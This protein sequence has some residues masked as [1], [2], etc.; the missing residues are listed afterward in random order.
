MDRDSRRVAV[1]SGV[2]LGDAFLVCHQSTQ[3]TEAPLLE[4]VSREVPVTERCATNP[5]VAGSGAQVTSTAEPVWMTVIVPLGVGVGGQVNFADANGSIH[6]AMVPNGL[7][8]G[9]SFSVQVVKRSVFQPQ[10][11]SLPPNV[12]PGDTLR[13]CGFDACER[14]VVVPEGV[15]PYGTFVC[16]LEVPQGLCGSPMGDVLSESALAT[17]VEAARAFHMNTDFMLDNIEG[18]DEP[19]FPGLMRKMKEVSAG[20]ATIQLLGDKLLLSQILDNLQVPQMPLLLDVCEGA[21]V[22][23][24]VADFVDQ[25]LIDSAC[26][27]I[28]KPTHLSNADGVKTVVPTCAE[29]R[30][31]AVQEIEA[32]IQEFMANRANENE[33]LALQSL[34]PGFVAQPMYQSDLCQTGLPLEL[35]LTALWGEVRT[36]VWWWGES[37]PWNAWIVR[38]ATDPQKWDVCHN[39]DA[40]DPSF[41]AALEIF[42]RHMPEMAATTG[43]IAAAVG[44]PFLR[45]DFFLGSSAFGVRLNEVAYGSGIE[46]RRSEQGSDELVNDSAVLAQILQAGFD[47]CETASPPGTFLGPLGVSG[48]SYK[49]M[50][51]HRRIC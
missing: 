35:R 12:G 3:N 47:V 46:Y 38:N 15:P 43:R 11:V 25:Y 31:S 33:S 6:R 32:H 10:Y 36:A 23:E 29:N 5:H 49:D 17:W 16:M 18:V 21:L 14:E 24:R 2:V 27:F 7:T 19:D 28:L 8:V 50:V 26:S 51:V 37:M 42:I 41:Q 39:H 4:T 30:D 48:E 44:A 13:V 34:R 9:D 22:S 40:Q 45:A 1:S 20:K